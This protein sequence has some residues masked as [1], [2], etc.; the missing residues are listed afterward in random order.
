MKTLCSVAAAAS[1]LLGQASAAII[2]SHNVV[3]DADT[4]IRGGTFADTN[5]GSSTQA[6]FSTF[7]KHNAR[8]ER[9][10]LIRFDLSKY[11]NIENV[12]LNV[13]QGRSTGQ[14]LRIVGLIGVSDDWDENAITYNTAKEGGF[15]DLD[16]GINL[17]SVSFGRNEHGNVQ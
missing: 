17:G 4:F 1:L 12:V 14:K 11:T 3:V 2:S 16:S 5:Y 15:L 6:E 10:A 13:T 7:N 9:H 8:H